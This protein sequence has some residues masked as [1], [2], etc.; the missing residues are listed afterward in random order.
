MRIRINVLYIYRL[1]FAFTYIYATEARH[2]A[3]EIVYHPPIF[4]PLFSVALLRQFLLGRANR[5]SPLEQACEIQS[6]E[7]PFERFIFEF[8]F[9]IHR[10]VN[11]QYFCFYFHQIRFKKIT[12]FD[13][14]D[15]SL[16]FY[17]KLVLKLL[18][19]VVRRVSLKLLN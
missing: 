12:V 17:K 19:T 6:S 13:F 9:L 15:I 1:K 5:V 10:C 2:D 4:S 18:Q 8:S 3:R 14:T 7:K 16:N 11:L